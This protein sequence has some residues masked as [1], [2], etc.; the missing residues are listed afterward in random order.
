VDTNET[1]GLTY[2]LDWT[3]EY[4]V[5]VNCLGTGT[6]AVNKGAGGTTTDTPSDDADGAGSADD[7]ATGIPT[8]SSGS[9][10]E[11]TRS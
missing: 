4:D 3:S 2:A 9:G 7:T 5:T 8:G 1:Y 6:L 10:D 11:S